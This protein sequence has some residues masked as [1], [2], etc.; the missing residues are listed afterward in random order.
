MTT[1]SLAQVGL[2][3]MKLNWAWYLVLGII[4]VGLGFT[5]IGAS[6]LVTKMSVMFIGW[7]LI[8]AGFMEA[9]YAF[10]KERGWSGFFIDLLAGIL[11]IVVGIQ[12]FFNGWSIVMLSLSARKL[13]SE[14]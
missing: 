4:L 3:E 5:A 6:V 11:Y 7:L 2:Q 1:A 8:L 14:A 13:P 12:M 9:V 10:W